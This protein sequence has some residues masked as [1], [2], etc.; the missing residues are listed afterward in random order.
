MK[1]L[2]LNKQIQANLSKNEEASIKGGGA[3]TL[4]TLTTWCIPVPEPAPP[5]DAES[6]MQGCPTATECDCP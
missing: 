5:S 4:F 2:K 3:P 6:C 1:K